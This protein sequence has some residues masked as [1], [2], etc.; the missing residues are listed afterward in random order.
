MHYLANLKIGKIILWCYL[1][2]YVVVVYFY[3]D[4]AI[5]IWL[6]SIG[7]SVV[8]GF[9]LKLSVASLAKPDRWQ[10]FRLFAMPF[11]V[12]S[13]SALIKDKGFYLIVPPNM[14]EV[15]VA[16]GG[17]LSFVVLVIMIKAITSKKSV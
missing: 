4:P 3:F 10:T 2:W 9:A 11:C 14:S 13:F 12:S 6:N 7:I 16:V 17:C 15:L 5:R 8:I 1:I